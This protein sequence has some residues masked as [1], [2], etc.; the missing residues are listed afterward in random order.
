MK[1]GLIS[2]NQEERNNEK[3][4]CDLEMR[5]CRPQAVEELS[6]RETTVST[7]LSGV[8]A[9]TVSNGVV[10]GN[11]TLPQQPCAKRVKLDVN[12][13][14]INADVDGD[15]GGGAD[16]VDGE[17]SVKNNSGGG[18]DVNVNLGAD[19]DFADTPPDREDREV[20]QT[21]QIEE[22]KD[23]Q[24]TT[25]T[26]TE[27]GDVPYRI[28]LSELLPPMEEEENV[29]LPLENLTDEEKEMF[30]RGVVEESDDSSE[31]ELSEDEQGA[32]DQEVSS[33]DSQARI[34]GSP[35][36]P[37]S[38]SVEEFSDGGQAAEPPTP[39]EEV[40]EGPVP[41]YTKNDLRPPDMPNEIEFLVKNAASYTVGRS[42]RSDLTR[43][44]KKN[45][46][47]FRLFVFPRGTTYCNGDAISAFLEVD[48]APEVEGLGHIDSRWVFQSV[49]YSITVVNWYDY[50]KSV[51]KENTWTFTAEHR[52]R[53]WHEFVPAS[54][55]LDK[56]KGWLSANG[57]IC[58]RATAV[59]SR[60][61]GI[62]TG[63]AYQSKKE[64]GYVGLKNHGATCYMNSL[65]QSL[66]LLGKF[67][68]LVYSLDFDEQPGKETEEEETVSVAQALQEVF[69]KMQTTDTAQTTKRLMK[70]FGW[71]SLEAF[72]QHDA[73]EL[74]RLLCDRLETLIQNSSDERTRS[75][76]GIIKEMF[77]GQ[78]T[79]YIECMDC[80]YKS[81]RTEAFW[82]IQL[83]IKGQKGQLLKNV[84]EAFDDFVT[85]EILQDENAYDAGPELG[86]QRARKGIR[87]EK[88]PPILNL[89][90]KR[91][92]FDM[93]KFEM[94]K[95]NNRF[96]FSEKLD[97]SK[98]IPEYFS[99]NEP[100]VYDLHSVVVHR[101]DVHAGHYYV[102]C[103]PHV[104]G[105]WLKFDDDIVT[106]CSP[107]A[108]VEDNFGGEDALITNYFENVTPKAGNTQSRSRIHSAYMLVYLRSDLCEELIRPP[109]PM[110]VNPK[111]V[112]R[113]AKRAHE[114]EEKR[115]K[116]IERQHKITVQVLFNKDLQKGTGFWDFTKVLD[117]ANCSQVLKFCDRDKTIKE[118]LNEIAN[119][120]QVSIPATHLAL[121]FLEYRTSP[122]EVARQV[123]FAHAA[124]SNSIRALLPTFALPHFDPLEPV[125]CVYCAISPKYDIPGGSIIQLETTD[126]ILRNWH[127][128]HHMMLVVKYFCRKVGKI[129]TLGGWFDNVTKTM[130]ESL[131]PW[132]L[133][134][135]NSEDFGIH[136][137][138][139]AS[140]KIT[141]KAWEEF[142]SKDLQERSLE[143]SP[144]TEGLWTGDV[145][146]LQAFDPEDQIKLEGT[147]RLPR[148][149][150]EPVRSVQDYSENLAN[151]TEVNVILHDQLERWTDE[152]DDETVCNRK[153]VSVM[154]DKRWSVSYSSAV[155]AKE[156]DETEEIKQEPSPDY[157]LFFL[158]PTKQMTEPIN[159][160]I[161]TLTP[162]AG[163]SD[164]DISQ[165]ANSIGDFLITNF[166]CSVPEETSGPQIT[167]TKPTTFHAVPNPLKGQTKRPFCV[168]IFSDH[169]V[170]IKCVLVYLDC[171]QGGN[172]LAEHIVEQVALEFD[173]PNPWRILRID[174]AESK[175][176]KV[177]RCGDRVPSALTGE[178]MNIFCDFLRL[179]AD[180][181]PPGDADDTPVDSPPPNVVEFYHADA[182]RL[183][184]AAETY[185]LYGQPALLSVPRTEIFA[186]TKRRLAKKLLVSDPE[187][188][189]WRFIYGSNS[190]AV[191]DEDVL[192]QS[193]CAS[194]YMVH[195]RNKRDSRHNR[196]LTMKR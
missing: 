196:A 149:P 157:W 56:S 99:S 47:R 190:A 146:I 5:D 167:K 179:E 4:D 127:E 151:Q 83:N 54:H 147:S 113:C 34:N 1:D 168:R 96:E 12:V 90:L 21:A 107:Y 105:R 134:R 60:A 61:E 180:D 101:G 182:P 22:K 78:M 186:E 145:V 136:A 118:L 166:K 23:S 71:D 74:N 26:E 68:E 169:V 62:D 172:V 32:K 174:E 72:T 76:K 159:D 177:Y 110:L 69:Y 80:D 97:V 156:L 109:D 79:N 24:E 17:K 100:H 66:F 158:P 86:K 31:E 184:L 112:E 102:C 178:Q 14:K 40:T 63:Y 138:D 153:K 65:L 30:R 125:F 8:R 42:I 3:Q 117:P 142:G 19:G 33:P 49:S 28:S 141:W 135:L 41:G 67:R 176:R 88:F 170:E 140:D 85:E 82:D 38:L 6:S 52:D 48:P 39:L 13:T 91:F 93:E 29:S 164:D 94:V 98:Y 171:E 59:C 7:N 131:I 148:F 87:F 155:I 43:P 18:N 73:Q 27:S 89:Q 123:R 53:G 192:D 165:L 122:P 70:S 77:E 11:D 154:L 185:R 119:H 103:R 132:V 2:H 20:P 104:N 16:V 137:M 10:A 64:T 81:E 115:R 124:L 143:A 25:G 163:E 57:E 92:Q 133:V 120:P 191:R 150:T 160:P 58:I 195:D 9:A 194:I 188:R 130:K 139:W 45:A 144:K 35:L 161:K 37:A 50:R 111:M 114:L 51:T 116:K 36:N 121:F 44:N 189:R 175:I 187:I 128:E 108:A 75:Q 181:C 183:S 106:H 173:L 152:T 129:V 126:N 162:V 15:E 193:C 55:L 84:E 95:L 46:F